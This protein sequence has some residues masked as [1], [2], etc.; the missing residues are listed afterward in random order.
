MWNLQNSMSSGYLTLDFTGTNL[1][2]Y[3]GNT[4]PQYS[5]SNYD[6]NNGETIQLII[7]SLAG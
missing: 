7:E 2:F 3:V 6:L 1:T 5:V 4:N